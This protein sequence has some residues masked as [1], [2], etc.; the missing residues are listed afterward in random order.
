MNDAKQPVFGPN[1]AVL[2]IADYGPWRKRTG[3]RIILN[4]LR[5]R[6]PRLVNILA[7]SI[8]AGPLNP[9]LLF[10]MPLTFVL[11]GSNGAAFYWFVAIPSTI[12]AGLGA[13]F[14]YQQDH[15]CA[16]I[17]GV[18]FKMLRWTAIIFTAPFLMVLFFDPIIFIV[19]VLFAALIVSIIGIPAALAGALVMRYVVFE[20]S[21]AD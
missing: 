16:S 8:F 10:W 4:P 2:K 6:E 12:A 9:S 18:A 1:G 21:R 17:F 15:D 5:K 13:I 19:V 11:N 3:P 7:S 14:F 20:T